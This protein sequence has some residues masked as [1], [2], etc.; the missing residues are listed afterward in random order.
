MLLDRN[1]D[2]TRAVMRAGAVTGFGLPS[3]HLL[4]LS[5]QRTDNP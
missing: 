5:S 2:S 3:D 1:S 4:V